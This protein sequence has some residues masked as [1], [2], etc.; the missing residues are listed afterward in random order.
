MQIPQLTRKRE[1]KMDIA[2]IG[3]TSP[4]LGLRLVGVWYGRG[5]QSRRVALAV[6]RQNNFLLGITESELAGKHCRG[7]ID[8][9]RC[10]HID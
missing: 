6:R 7:L 1:T 4:D 9:Y 10:L 3:C 8:R 2:C 5:A